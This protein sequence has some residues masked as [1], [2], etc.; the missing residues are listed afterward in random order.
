MY[1][2]LP[3]I[4]LIFTPAAA[5]DVVLCNGR[6]TNRPCED[7]QKV[8]EEAPPAPPSSSNPGTPEVSA[9]R[10]LLHDIRMK[11][12]NARRKY[13]LRFEL[14]SLEHFCLETPST[15][16]Q[17]AEKIAEVESK[18]DEKIVTAAS[19]KQEEEKLRLQQ[20]ANRLQEERNRIEA[21]RSTVTVVQPRVI[22]P[23]TPQQRS[24][25]MAQAR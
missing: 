7:P 24:T 3:F 6:W 14:G 9:K 11:A 4:F 20:E 12:L 21:E 19:L 15:K 18:L 1:R 13:D 23:T 2:A 8:L 25:L 22:S 17:C 16:E 5:A 10:S